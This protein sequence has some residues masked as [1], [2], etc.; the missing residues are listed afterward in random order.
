M[1]H[2]VPMSFQQSEQR[3]RV[4]DRPTWRQNVNIRFVAVL[5]DRYHDI[6]INFVD[7]GKRAAQISKCTSISSII[8]ASRLSSTLCAR[9][10]KCS[11]F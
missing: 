11:K 3:D 10:R 2:E 1:Y 9:K 8:I 6:E 4:K 5:Y 7:Y